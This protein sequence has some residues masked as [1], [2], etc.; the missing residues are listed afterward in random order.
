MESDVAQIAVLAG[1]YI[2][3]EIMAA[4]L[5]VLKAVSANQFAYQLHAVP[6]GGSAID[7]CGE[8]L[9]AETLKTCQACDAILL[10]AVGGPKWDHVSKRPESGLLAIRQALQLFANIRPTRISPAVAQYSPLKQP[11][12]VDFAIIRELTS[13]IYF[14]QPRV[15]ETAA[16]LDTMSYQRTEITRIAALAFK[17]AESRQHHVTLVDKANVLATSKLWR[18]VVEPIAAAHPDVSYD[19]MYVD[20]AAMKIIARPDQFDVILTANLFG[21][22]LSDEAAEITGSLGT[23]PSISEG[24]HGPALYEP[25]HGSAPDIAG[26]NIADPLAMIRSVALMLEHSF[27]RHDLATQITVAVDHVM[28]VGTV[29]PDLGGHQTTAEVTNAI[30]NYIQESREAYVTNH[31]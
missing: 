25:I 1:D 14:G 24:S 6:F 12:S 16:A 22:I 8:P 28:A 31:V 17:L 11:A 7:Q 3:P 10:A 26:Q 19:Q 9:P 20:A 2:G 13:G 27:G 15:L 29:T 21:D 5:A 23:I 18:Q 4:G 30:I